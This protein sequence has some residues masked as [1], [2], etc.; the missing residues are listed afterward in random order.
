M[1]RSF[2]DSMPSALRRQKL[3]Q[4]LYASK[5]I[6]PVQLLEYD[7]GAR[8]FVDLRD[9]E[10]RAA[11]LSQYFW[12]HIAPVVRA[13]LRGGG[14][15]FDVGANFGLFTFGAVSKQV[16]FHLFEANPRIIPT[17]RKSISLYPEHQIAVNHCCVTDRPGVS[18]LT[19]PDGS[20]GHGH[21]GGRG[22][23]IPNLIL[24]DYIER[25][26]VGRVSF[27][28][29]DVE[30]WEAHALRGLRKSV[31]SGM[32]EV[33][34]IE[35]IQEIL[36]RAGSSVEEVLE[37]LR[38]FDLYFCSWWEYP[39][40]Y[41][42]GGA[43]IEVGG[44]PLRFAPALPLPDDFKAADLLGLYKHTELARTVHGVTRTL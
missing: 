30:G 22:E 11:Y 10:S 19:L 3:L 40:P 42:L 26:A 12:P 8:A 23:E 44:T 14:E 27:L 41:G 37:L 9:A 6:D 31:A 36:E 28:K 39:D 34:F 33:V 21:M 38:D 13:F 1:L 4:L 15:M 25:N 24:D 18:R 7:D 20:W 5:I 43:R 17:L 32:V 16:K 29:V 35:V 2:L